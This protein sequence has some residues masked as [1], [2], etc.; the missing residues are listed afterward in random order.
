MVAQ[1]FSMPALQFTD[2]AS[3]TQ[4]PHPASLVSILLAK[5]HASAPQLF[6]IN[7][8]EHPPTQANMIRVGWRRE[9][10]V[11]VGEQNQYDRLIGLGSLWAT[12]ALRNFARART[13]NPIPP[14]QF[15]ESAA[16]IINTPAAEMQIGQLILLR[17]MLMES[18][19]RIICFW[20]ATGVALL[21]E[22]VVN[23]PK[24]LE[25]R[26]ANHQSAKALELLVERWAKNM[27]FDLSNA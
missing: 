20:G 16:L 9:A 5:F 13:S 2:P 19:D 8:P 27:N 7:A 17:H 22:A 15:W 10:N 4:T 26:V 23:M 6:G 12:S 21:R 18:V 14:L 25:G 11:F 3:S 24:R 1:V